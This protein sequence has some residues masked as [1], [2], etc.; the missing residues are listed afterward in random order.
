M[1]KPN[2]ICDECGKE[3]HR[4]DSVDRMQDKLR[5]TPERKRGS[6]CSQE[7]SRM[8]G[9]T[10]THC[11]VCHKGFAIKRNRF[12]EDGYHVCGHECLNI[13]RMQK[14]EEKKCKK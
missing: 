14:R 8:H 3:F 6:F 1:P 7:C 4:Y 9:W 13:L 12:K 2:R 10:V 5:M 11:R